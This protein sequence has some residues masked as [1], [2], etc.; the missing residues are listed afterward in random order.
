MEVHTSD[1]QAT[2]PLRSPWV[3]APPPAFFVASFMAGVALARVAPLPLV[4]A[5][6]YA[7]ARAIGIGAIVAASVLILSAPVLF[8][9]HRT[10]IV[11]HGKARSLIIAGPYR[12]TRNPMYVGLTAA[13]I[14]AALVVNLLW[15]LLFVVLPLWVLQTKTIPFEERSLLAIFGD[16]YRAYQRR[17]RRWL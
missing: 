15:P 13:Y 1:T 14:G 3:V 5:S 6:M 12:I 16:E 10:T 7:L 11:P 2:K 4:G 8:L 17:V 9:R